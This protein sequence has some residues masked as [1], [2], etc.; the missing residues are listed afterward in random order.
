MVKDLV[1]YYG[2]DATIDMLIEECGE[3]IHA[4]SHYKRA[5]GNGFEISESR[6]M[7]YINLVNAFADAANAAESVAYILEMD[8]DYIEEVIKKSDKKAVKKLRKALS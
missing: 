5:K 8:A 6:A 2:E 7:A 1:D 3:L 4:L